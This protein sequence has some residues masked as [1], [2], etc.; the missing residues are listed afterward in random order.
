V[1]LPQRT[2][3]I[4]LSTATTFTTP[5]TNLFTGLVA[6]IYDIKVIDSKGCESANQVTVINPTPIAANATATALLVIVL[7][8]PINRLPLP[9]HQ[10]V[11]QERTRIVMIMAD[12]MDQ[13]AL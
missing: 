6:G 5:S 4:K 2:Y 12:R 1:V 8:T 10:Q 11:E 3:A 9:L 7:P 13:T